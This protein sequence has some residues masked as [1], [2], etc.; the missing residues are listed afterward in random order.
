MSGKG[1]GWGGFQVG[2]R[3]GL[4]GAL[5]LVELCPQEGLGAGHWQDPRGSTA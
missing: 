3:A 4:E 1:V 5:A 2:P